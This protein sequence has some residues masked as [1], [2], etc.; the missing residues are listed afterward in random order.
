MPS[1]SRRRPGW[2]RAAALAVA[3]LGIVTACSSA[4]PPPSALENNGG[5]PNGSTAPQAVAS[6]SASA[7]AVPV[8]KTLADGTKV[9]T[10]VRNGQVIV[11]TTKNGKTTTSTR[12]NTNT[13]SGPNTAAAPTR[14]HLFT[15][16]ENTIGITPTS[17]TMCAHAALTYGKAFQT[18]VSD[19]NVFWSAVNDNGGIYGRKVTVTYENDNYKPDTAVQAATTCKDKGIFMLLGGIGFDQ[20][21]AV[22]NWAEQNHMLYMHHT[23]T[24]KG[25][26][27]QKYSFAPLPSVERTGEAFGQLYESKYHGKK[28]G[29]IKRDGE[30]WEPG[31]DAFKAYLASHGDG[32][33]VVAEA[34]VAQN[35]GNY[36]DA[37]LAM[38][39][40]GA[41]VVWI[42]ENALDGIPIV[43][44]IRRQQYNPH[45]LLFPF[46]LTS[47]TLDDD[48]FN[49][50]LD[51]VAMYSAYS[52]QDYSGGFAT[53]ADDM[54][55]FEAQYK[56]YDPSA[57]LSGVSG[58]LLFLNWTAQKSLYAQLLDC[59]KDCTR[60]KF[61]DVLESYNKR[62]TSS[63][64]LENF[65]GGN[66][67]SG[68]SQLVFM[69][70]YRDP[71]GKAGWRPTRQCVGPA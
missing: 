21:P 16:A 37:V 42:W 30:N 25:T 3:S 2:G 65:T 64:C 52:Y 57:N 6:P 68:G 9:T 27:G 24:I 11:T 71:R 38:K 20:I 28:V 66:H 14:S 53:Y 32:K 43:Q 31:V 60:N 63:A 67:R 18:D 70:T 26:A 23:A 44:Q 1:P 34:K 17:L 4:P 12:P 56:K 35:Q 29:V 47:Q 10:V 54:K 7:L 49:P 36:T 33:A 55:L 48:A 45:M 15:E 13:A 39:N 5:T 51:G 8:T 22:R 41:E 59:G 50:P 19:L 69:E 40:A 58:D 46:N 62:P 61:V